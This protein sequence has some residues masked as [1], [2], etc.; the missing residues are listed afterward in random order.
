MMDKTRAGSELHRNQDIE[1][2]FQDAHSS[3]FLDIH[4]TMLY[5]LIGIV[6]LAASH[7]PLIP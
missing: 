2:N 7:M 4:A 5:E 3:P 1:V 6:R